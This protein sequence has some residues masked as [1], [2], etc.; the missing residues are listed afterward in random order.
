MFER[1]TERARDVLVQAGRLAKEEKSPAIR[2]HHLLIGIIDASGEGSQSV[3]MV[4]SDANVDSADLRAKLLASLRATQGPG[5]AK[6]SPPFTAEAKKA[7]ELS[8]REALSLGHN[9]IGRE[10]LLLGILRDAEPPLATVLDEAGLDYTRAREIVRE[11]SPPSRRAMRGEP[12]ERRIARRLGQRATPAVSSVLRQAYERAEGRNTTTGDLLLALLDQTGT[13]FVT[14]LKDVGLDAASIATTVNRL[15]DTR[16]P[17]GTDEAVKVD[18]S[19]AVLI[20]DPRIADAL[21][22]LVGEAGATPD[23]L[24]EIL[25]RLQG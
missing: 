13:H 23:Q 2:R 21:K 17:D 15:I 7:L 6:D 25:R 4:F 12:L 11:Q 1:F 19:G 20:S 22:K 18:P 8:L 24:E 3:A 9:Y 5:E 14:A 16:V 10:H